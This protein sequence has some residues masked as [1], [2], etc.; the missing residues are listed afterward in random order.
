M[1]SAGSLP[2]ALLVWTM[3]KA[4]HAALPAA[5]PRSDPRLSMSLDCSEWR[6]VLRVSL[7]IFATGIP[8]D[9]TSLHLGAPS[10]ACGFTSKEP[11][12]PFVVV[13][14]DYGLLDCGSTRA[15][16][17]QSIVYSNPFYHV[18]VG[19]L[20]GDEAFNFSVECD[21]PRRGSV[22]F[23]KDLLPQQEDFSDLLE[24]VGS[25][26]FS[27]TIMDEEWQQ[28]RSS[29]T[30]LL[31]GAV[32][33][34]ARVQSVGGGHLALR[35]F[36]DSC[37]ATPG[38]GGD[39]DCLVDGKGSGA[40]FVRTA[41][42]SALRLS[43]PAFAFTSASGSST[44]EIYLH[45]DLHVADSQDDY[46]PTQKTCSFDQVR[47]EWRMEDEVSLCELC[48]CCDGDCSSEATKQ[49]R[50][51]RGHAGQP[52]AG[53][54]ALAPC[55]CVEATWGPLCLCVC[56]RARGLR[57]GETSAARRGPREGTERRAGTRGL[58]LAAR[59]LAQSRLQTHRLL[60]VLLL[61]LLLLLVA[62]HQG[63]HHAAVLPVGHRRRRIGGLLRPVEGAVRPP[64][65]LRGASGAPGRAVAPPARVG[66]ALRRP[67]R[68][69]RWCSRWSRRR[70]RSG[71][72][73]G[74]GGPAPTL[75]GAGRTSFNSRPW[76]LG[77]PRSRGRFGV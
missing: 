18:P 44:N 3:S 41:D 48:A 65:R 17:N 39:L 49:R 62:L 11:G 52:A 63:G 69:W 73:A 53:T 7:D 33:L 60:L 36:I 61:V 26:N 12:H 5:S 1:A 59:P 71:G 67:K 38:G 58:D 30:F 20:E 46:S 64:L 66:A 10:R 45:C 50:R 24:A 27:L 54:A 55:C 14:F 15:L 23:E 9:E 8:V 43:F 25:F 77:S 31:G 16:T 74:F 34:E 56:A 32:N 21:Y 6:F 29:A 47:S 4:A 68:R 13:V 35:L 22:S 51:R 75:R 57:A 19:G 70:W 28:P 76:M 40:V 72:V 42:S 2:W 37:I